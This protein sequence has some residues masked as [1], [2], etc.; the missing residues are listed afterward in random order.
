MAC[1]LISFKLIY[2]L[3]DKVDAKINVSD[4]DEI[5]VFMKDNIELEE[6]LKIMSEGINNVNSKPPLW[7]IKD[8]AS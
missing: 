3:N 4:E 8:L 7:R 6:Q 2:G 1:I 5:L